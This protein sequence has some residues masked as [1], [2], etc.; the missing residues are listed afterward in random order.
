[1]ADYQTEEERYTEEEQAVQDIIRNKKINTL[2]GIGALYHTGH[3]FRLG[4]PDTM[5]LFDPSWKSKNGTQYEIDNFK[6]SVDKDK[7]PK[8][9][10][11]T[12]S[13][14]VVEYYFGGQKKT[15]YYYKTNYYPGILG[16]TAPNI[17]HVGH[18]SI[19]LSDKEISE[20]LMLLPIG[21]IILNL[22]SGIALLD[23]SKYL[24]SNY[25]LDSLG[26][27]VFS[28]GDF[29]A[30]TTS[31]FIKNRNID[32]EELVLVLQFAKLFKELWGKIGDKSYYEECERLRIK[33]KD[34][35]KEEQEKYF[36]QEE[37][38]WEIQLPDWPERYEKL[39]RAMGETPEI[40]RS[41]IKRVNKE[42]IIKII[43]EMPTEI[44][45]PILGK[46]S[47]KQT[48]E[49]TLLMIGLM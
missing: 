29:G 4:F 32:E 19:E 14:D 41:I 47:H 45:D 6:Q 18:R 10:Q 34:L 1:M 13:L 15:I 5:L 38:C 9:I 27:Y 40:L 11:Q 42:K 28:G 36:L 21:T 2:L 31:I 26:N 8:F 30:E 3:C 23:F 37:R 7:P 48:L 39:K 12:N 33:M 17:F 46:R 44:I 16:R 20:S 49:E 25:F 43:T 35:S 24:I 22:G